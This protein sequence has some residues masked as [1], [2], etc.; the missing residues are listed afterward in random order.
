[1]IS[2]HHTNKFNISASINSSIYERSRLHDIGCNGVEE[3][4]YESH[5]EQIVNRANV[6]DFEEIGEQRVSFEELLIR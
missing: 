6:W 2:K 4:E 5:Y 3:Q 1:L